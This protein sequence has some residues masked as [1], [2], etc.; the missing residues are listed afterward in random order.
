MMLLLSL[1]LFVVDP[2]P[3]AGV[4]PVGADGKPLNL[5]FETGTLK[6]WVAEGDA[7]RD[8]PIPGDTVH[9]RRS[10][11]KSDH[12]GKYWIGGYEK[13]GDKPQGTLTSVPFKVTHPWATFLVGGGAYPKE[14]CVELVDVATKDVFFRASGVEEENLKRV[15]V[16]LAKHQGREIQIRVVDRHTGHWGHVNFDDFRFHSEQPQAHGRSSVGVPPDEYKH[17]GLSPAD[18]AKA[19]TVPNG[20]S[21]SVFAAEP[22]VHQPIAFCF[23]DRGRM[24]VVE[25]YTYPKR[26]PTPAWRQNLDLGRHRWRRQV[27]QEDRVHGGLK[28]RLRN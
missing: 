24:W 19:M 18:A 11:N 5:D 16:D 7:F 14:T 23:D 26:N 12:Q 17:A 13:H 6:D 25:A 3:P 1:L 21:V 4:L 27:R 8:Q 20:F 22:D 15:S 9:P 28:P 2:M 10:D